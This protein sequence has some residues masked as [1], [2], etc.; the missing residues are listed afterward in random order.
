MIDI[1]VIIFLFAF[2]HS[3]MASNRFKRAC[4]GLFGDMFMRAYYRALYNTVSLITAAIA[5]TLIAQAPDHVLWIAPVW[6]WWTMRGVQ[7][8]GAVII[9]LAFQHLDGG[10]FLGLRQV[11]RRLSHGETAGNIDGLTQTELITTG[12]YGIVRH[13]MYLGGI[14]IFTFDPHI[15]RNGL[16]TTLC[17]DIYFLFGMLIEERRFLDVFG[18]RYTEYAKRVAR[19]VPRMKR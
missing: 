4:T 8:T 12:V 5:F 15:T 13:P 1:A 3:V 14:I 9:A 7:L 10:E 19:F 6:L 18:E 16:I 17:A 2:L 11:W